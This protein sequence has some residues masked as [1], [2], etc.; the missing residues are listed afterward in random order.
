MTPHVGGPPGYPCQ[1]EAVAGGRCPLRPPDPPLEPEDAAVHLHRAQ[2]HPHH[3]P[4]ADRHP[5][6]RRDHVRPRRRRDRSATSSSSAPRSRPAKRSRS[7]PAAP[8]CPYVNNRWLGGTLTNFRTIQ[9]RIRHLHEP[10]DARWRAATY[11]RLTKKEQ[12]DISNEIERMNRYFGGIK[13]MDRLPAAV[14]I[15]D[16][17]KEADRRRRVRAPEH[18]DRLAGRHELRPGPG[19]LP[20]PEQRRRHPRH[21]AHPRQDRRCGHRRPRRPRIG[22]PAPASTSTT[23]RRPAAGGRG[24]RHVLGCARR[25]APL[26]KRPAHR[27]RHLGS[28]QAAAATPRRPGRRRSTR[29]GVSHDRG[30]HH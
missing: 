21:Q 18:P 5:P 19:R 17:V 9:S 23:S 2:R 14:F 3:R 6:R 4:A 20:D 24:S 27:H 26:P 11:S 22:L 10:R 7:K 29:P 12:L 13:N 15:I 8:A 28:A 30:S 1:H 25:R 16:T